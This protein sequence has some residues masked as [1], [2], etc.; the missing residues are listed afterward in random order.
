MISVCSLFPAHRGE[1]VIEKAAGRSGHGRFLHGGVHPFFQGRPDYLAQPVRILLQN[2]KAPDTVCGLVRNIGRGQSAQVLTLAQ[3][4]QTPVDMFTTACTS[5][6]ATPG[7]CRGRMVTPR[8]T[9]YE[10]S[11]VQRHHRGP[12][13]SDSWPSLGRTF[14]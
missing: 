6:T 14:W 9:A 2:G 3:L 12:H 8:G 4:E 10:G 7:C 1:G 13:F 11:G 5:A